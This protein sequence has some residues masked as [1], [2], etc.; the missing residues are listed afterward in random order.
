M[1][2]RKSTS[3]PP[4]PLLVQVAG[5]RSVEEIL[6]RTKGLLELIELACNAARSD[7]PNGEGV[8]DVFGPDLLKSLP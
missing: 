6:T 2:K 3:P 5:S 8:A 4:P 1:T 7:E